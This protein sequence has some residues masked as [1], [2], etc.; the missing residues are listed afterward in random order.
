MGARIVRAVRNINVENRAHRLIEKE[1][2]TA[3][4]KHPTTAKKIDEFIQST[5]GAA[6]EISSKHEKLNEFLKQV[7]VEST[8]PA[9]PLKKTDRTDR[10]LP[11]STKKFDFIDSLDA[12]SMVPEGRLSVPMLLEMLSKHRRSPEEFTAVKLADEYRINVEDTKNI[13]EYF[14]AF[15]LVRIGPPEEIRKI[16]S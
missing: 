14:K 4:P 1:K 11:Q 9:S 15:R 10:Q 3:A 6:Q 2:P 8:D 5:P 7:R 16:E 12:P 13:L